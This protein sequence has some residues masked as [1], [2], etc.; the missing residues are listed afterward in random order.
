MLKN[1][2]SAAHNF[3]IGDLDVRTETILPRKASKITF[4]PTET[5]TFKFWCSIAGYR[6]VGME[7]E[8]IVE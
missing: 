8:L 4:I 7:G 5:D 3:G 1:Q 6:D 2:G